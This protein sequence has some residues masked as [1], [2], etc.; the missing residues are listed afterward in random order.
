MGKYHLSFIFHFW[1]KVMLRSV[2]TSHVSRM[3]FAPIYLRPIHC[4]N[5][6]W[7]RTWRTDITDRIPE[8]ITHWFI[9]RRG[10]DQIWTDTKV[11]KTCVFSSFK[12]TICKYVFFKA[13]ELNLKPWLRLHDKNPD[14]DFRTHLNLCLTLSLERM[15]DKIILKQCSQANCHF[16]SWP[17]SFNK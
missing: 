12:F 4:R 9:W 11:S 14:W 6:K 15:K 1:R 8:M 2:E 5:R 17:S 10:P 13:S 16:I 3:S 7:F